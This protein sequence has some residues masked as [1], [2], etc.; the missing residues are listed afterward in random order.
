MSALAGAAVALAGFAV[1]WAVASGW[2][3]LGG[4]GAAVS[5]LREFRSTLRPCGCRWGITDPAEACGRCR[6]LVEAKRFS[7]VGEARR[8]YGFGPL[9]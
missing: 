4:R 5:G 1:G 7:T 8:R 3:P 2:L 6:P 9:E